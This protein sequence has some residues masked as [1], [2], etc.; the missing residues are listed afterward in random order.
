[1]DAYLGEIRMFCGTYAP[2]NWAFC[3]GQLLPVSSNTALF[4]L[5]GT[6]YGGNGTT[7][8]ALPDLRGKVP[9]SQGTGPDLS[10]RVVGDTGGV[11]AVTLTQK[12]M[13]AHNHRAQGL[14]KTGTSKSP[15]DGVWT[16]HATDVRPP[17]PTKL[18]APNGDV[19]MA[20]DAL[21]AAGGGQPHNNMQP[22]LGVNFIICTRG[23]FPPRA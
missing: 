11:P 17:V 3:Q 16:Q 23:I 15:V 9:I 18:F 12:E 14:T 1:M 7:N 4:S 8:F 21:A 13:P 10:E 20:A 6:A 19:Q 22:Y 5:L 2:A